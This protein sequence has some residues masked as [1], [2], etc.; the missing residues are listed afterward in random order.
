MIQLPIPNDRPL[1]VFTDLDGT[2]IDHHNYSIEGS[3]EAIRKLADREATLVF[4]SSKT[5]AEQIHLQHQ[6]GIQL[7]FIFENGSALA[8]PAGFFP[9]ELYA[10]NSREAGY[11]LLIFAHAEAPAIRAALSHFPE[12]RG[13]ADVS[14]LELSA[15][16]GLTGAFLHR[17]R[18]RWF[19]ETLID[20]FDEVEA[21]QIN[22]MLKPSGFVLSRGGRF[23]TVQ[24]DTVSKGKAVAWLK[25]VFRQTA[26]PT[27][28]FAAV[29]DSLNDVP[30]LEVVDWPFLVQ[31]PDQTWVDVDIPHLVKIE[32][33][34]PAGFS[35][36]VDS[37]LIMTS[38]LHHLK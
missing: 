22:Q 36:A 20:T 24:S 34:G 31:R 14:D 30:M 6:L 37:V 29:G 32:G 2:L 17:A 8:I 19:T 28:C 26:G 15:V 33:V 18:E 10:A 16:T 5:F 11:D 21:N 38:K 9:A 7:P 27:T 35:R 12:I 25:D 4:C 1:V 13:Y 3:R 23:Y